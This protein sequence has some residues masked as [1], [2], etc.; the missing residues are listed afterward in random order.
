MAFGLLLLLLL[1]FASDVS[2]YFYLVRSVFFL[3]HL[4]NEY[5]PFAALYRYKFKYLIEKEEE[6]EQQATMMTTTTST[7]TNK[8]KKKKIKRK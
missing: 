3:V 2:T 7:T 5:I 1:L 4:H 8:K 6:N